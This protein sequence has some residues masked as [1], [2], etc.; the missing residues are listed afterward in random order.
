MRIHA[1]SLRPMSEAQK[2]RLRSVGDLFYSDAKLGDDGIL[3]QARGAEILLITPRLHHDVTT[4]LDRCRFISWQAAGLDALNLAECRR[5]GIIVSNVPGSL[6]SD[7]VAE[8][9]W[10]LILSLAKRLPEGGPMLLNGEWTEALAYFTTGLRGRTLGLFGF[11]QI[12]QRIAEI[13]LG[14]GMKVIATIR[15]PS[16]DRTVETVALD[17][18]LQRSDFLVL[19]APVTAETTGLFD[20]AAFQKMQSAA[21]LVNISRGALVNEPD[22]VQALDAGLIAGAGIDVFEQEPPNPGNPLLSHPKAIVSPHVAWGT[23]SAVQALLDQS[24]ANVEAFLRGSPTN[25]VS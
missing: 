7:A 19:A 24:I 21:F 14:F 22:L 23:D 1:I 8:H 12:G 25:V 5:K 20:R 13:G 3:E 11:G 15:D 16:K 4:V 17:E 18:L 10:A 2:D 6:L 9:A